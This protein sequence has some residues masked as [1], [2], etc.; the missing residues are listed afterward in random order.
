VDLNTDAAEA[1]VPIPPGRNLA[2]DDEQLRAHAQDAL[3]RLA[4]ERGGRTVG[5]LRYVGTRPWEN[6]PSIELSMWQAD[7]EVL[8]AALTTVVN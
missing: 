3:E 8:D 6:D 5:D 1:A 2:P 7:C 4:A